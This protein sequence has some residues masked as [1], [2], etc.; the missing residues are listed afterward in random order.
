MRGVY[1]KVLTAGLL[2]LA[3]S[4]AFAQPPGR[5]GGGGF[6]QQPPTIERLLANKD[7]QDEL[8]ISDDQ[9]ADIKKATDTVSAKYKDD[10]DKAR[11]DMDRQKVGELRKAEAADQEKALAAV[12]K[13]EQMKRAKQLQVQLSGIAAFSMEDVESAL[14]L[15]DKQKDDIKEE[16][17]G[18]Q[19]DIRDLF[20]SAGMDPDKRADA[21]KKIQAMR[22]ESIGKI[23]DGLTADQKK[24]WQDLTGEKTTIVLAQGGFG[25]G[26]GGF[27]PGGGAGPGGGLFGGFGRGMGGAALLG[28]EKVATE[29]KLTD[30]QKADV[31]KTTDTV[32]AK[33][34]DEM[35][36]ARQDM[37]REKMTEIAKAQNADLDKALAGVLKP[38]QTK[39]LKQIEVQVAGPAAF[40]MEDVDSALKLTDAQKKDIKDVND[41]LQ[42]DVQDAFQGAFQG[43][44]NADKMQEVMKKVQ[45]IRSDAVDKIAKGLT[46]DQ[47]KTWKDL[48]GDKFELNFSDF[49]RPG[50][51]ARP[52]NPNP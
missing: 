34:R 32:N 12:L 18:L 36:K 35:T 27:A 47:K 9:K 48:A 40:S 45:T 22:N 10:I 11:A 5:P 38:E 1:A 43:G 44:F 24:T 8:K 7:V 39:R 33:Y 41:S 20:Q 14:K 46:D 21:Q 52:P 49:P 50:G 26:G 17:K 6:G 4:P 42:K 2:V 29:L 31:K 19:D 28:V 25:P 13:P 15:T 51:G 3:A 16:A 23:V 37:D 30:D